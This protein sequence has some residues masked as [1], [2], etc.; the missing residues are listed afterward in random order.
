[1]LYSSA[2]YDTH[3]KNGQTDLFKLEATKSRSFKIWNSTILD[4]ISC[5]GTISLFIGSHVMCPFPIREQ[6]F[7]MKVV[8]IVMN[9]RN[10]IESN[11][12]TVFSE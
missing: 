9:I 10:G 1:M 3:A 5:S 8:Y 7:G 11:P 12:S 6:E 4:H 2:S